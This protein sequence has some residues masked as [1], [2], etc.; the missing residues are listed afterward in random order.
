MYITHP[1]ACE[2]VELSYGFVHEFG[3]E[4]LAMLIVVLI[5]EGPTK[6]V[7]RGSGFEDIVFPHKHDPLTISIVL[8]ET[9]RHMDLTLHPQAEFHS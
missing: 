2:S 6:L 7:G 9:H 5:F 1:H 8:V 3:C 4:G